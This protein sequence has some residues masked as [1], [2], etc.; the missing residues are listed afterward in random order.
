G[1]ELGT[2]VAHYV[3]DTSLLPS[4]P[5]NDE[6]RAAGGV[7]ASVPGARGLAAQ[8]LFVGRNLFAD[9]GVIRAVTGGQAATAAGGVVVVA[10]APAGEA[11][12]R[13]SPDHHRHGGPARPAP[14]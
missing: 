5:G 6:H 12:S 2:N 8:A 14:R 1:L 9:A 10:P 3:L 7:A 11:P 4:G 13:A